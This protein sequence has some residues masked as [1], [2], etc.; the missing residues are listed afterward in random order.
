MKP[1]PKLVRSYRHEIKPVEEPK[2]S[3]DDKR[4]EDLADQL[5]NGLIQLPYYVE[6]LIQIDKLESRR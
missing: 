3:R 1:K 6:Q 5:R 4:K 2:P